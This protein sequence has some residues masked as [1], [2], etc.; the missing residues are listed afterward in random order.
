[1]FLS[2]KKTTI[3]IDKIYA[4]NTITKRKMEKLY[5][6]IGDYI[7]RNSEVLSSSYLDMIYFSDDDKQIVYE[8]LGLDKYDI[9]SVISTIDEIKGFNV[10]T[11]PFAMAITMV[12]RHMLLNKYRDKEISLVVFYFGIFYYPSVFTRQF[13]YGVIENI[14]RY[15]IDNLNDKYDIKMEETRTIYKMVTKKGVTCYQTYEKGLI[16]GTDFEIT[17]FISQMSG[18][19]KNTITKISREYYANVEEGKYTNL[20]DESLDEDNYHETDSNSLEAK[21]CIDKARIRVSE[22]GT[23]PSIIRSLK[24]LPEVSDVS[25]TELRNAIIKINKNHYDKVSELIFLI[26]ELFM[27]DNPPSKIKDAEFFFICASIYSRSN[28]TDELV[29]D[30]KRILDYL[31]KVTSSTYR[32][33]NRQGTINSYKKALYYYYVILV[34]KSAKS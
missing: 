32:K 24:K 28:T 12:I 25:E 11:N 22:E 9:S 27:E 5:H 18:R 26:V 4:K 31:L 8:T 15:T 13:R 7:D 23:D 21:R 30:I 29:K 20:D 34:S 2:L 3:L 10:V 19:I 1:M 33:T 17:N 6:H 14:M 16:Q